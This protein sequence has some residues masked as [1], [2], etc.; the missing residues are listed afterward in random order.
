MTYGLCRMHVEGYFPAPHSAEE[1][2]AL[3]RSAYALLLRGA[4][5]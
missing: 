1:L 4:L 5:P 2:E 3:A